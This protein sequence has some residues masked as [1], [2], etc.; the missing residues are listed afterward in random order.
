MF[1]HTWHWHQHRTWASIVGLIGHREM[2]WYLNSPPTTS[3][4]H[5][6]SVLAAPRDGPVLSTHQRRKA[7]VD[8]SSTSSTRSVLFTA[9]ATAD[10]SP[11]IA[12]T[13]DDRSSPL[14]E[15]VWAL[16]WSVIWLYSANV[17]P[18]Q[19]SHWLSCYLHPAHTSLLS[20]VLVSRQLSHSRATAN[21]PTYQSCPS[22]LSTP[23]GHTHSSNTNCVSAQR[24]EQLHPN[25]SSHT[26]HSLFPLLIH[27]VCCT[28]LEL[29]AQRSTNMRNS[30]IAIAIN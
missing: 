30:A 14:R 5:R 2:C 23:Q 12:G 24:R 13:G 22:V 29:C 9:Y 1:W 15:G 21:S 17:L 11:T 18:T 28:S 7:Q 10:V 3:R 25:R 6:S 16:I 27:P 26:P 20:A 8:H 4:H 19:L